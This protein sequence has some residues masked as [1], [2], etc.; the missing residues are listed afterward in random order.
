MAFTLRDVPAAMRRE[1]WP[2]GARLMERWFASPAYA[3]DRRV[4]DGDLP[5]RANSVESRLVTMA[6]ALNFPRANAALVQLRSEWSGPPR[7]ARSQPVIA[8]QLRRWV[9]ARQ[10]KPDAPF[11]FGDLGADALTVDQTSAINFQAIDSNWFA[12]I[13]DFYAALG[14]ASI[15]IAVTGMVAADGA[16]WR[17]SIDEIGF[18]LRD[19]YDFIGAQRLGS[20]GPD[21]FSSAAIGAPAIEI[22]PAA[23]PG[24]WSGNAQYFTVDNAAFRRWRGQFGRGGDFVIFSD[25]R[26]SRLSSP[27]VVTVPR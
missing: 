11:R 12:A 7:L 9:A 27:V 13:D 20:W 18:Y 14:R 16:N 15:K 25:L 6:W 17:L 2:V 23:E 19:T 8:R 5:P 1:N 4:K 3:M 24:W 26:R 21:G 22:D 10:L